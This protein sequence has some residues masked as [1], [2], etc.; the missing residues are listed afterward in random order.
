MATTWEK[1]DQT[2]EEEN[3]AQPTASDGAYAKLIG[4]LFLSAFV[5]Y[6]V[7][8]AGLFEDA[9]AGLFEDGEGA[10]AAPRGSTALRAVLHFARRLAPFR[11][12]GDPLHPAALAGRVGGLQATLSRRGRWAQSVARQHCVSTMIGETLIVKRHAE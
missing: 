8:A 3:Q 9:L 11:P 2:T 12:A 1:R 4:A 5:L 7:L 10:Y 6:G